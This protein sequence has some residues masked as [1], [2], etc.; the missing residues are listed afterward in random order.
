MYALAGPTLV[1]DGMDPAALVSRAAVRHRRGRHRPRQFIQPRH[2]GG[3]RQRPPARYVAAPV[4]AAHRA[5]LCRRYGRA[6]PPVWLALLTV[7]TAGGAAIFLSPA[8]LFAF[9]VGSATLPSGDPGDAAVFEPAAVVQAAHWLATVQGADDIV[10]SLPLTGNELAADIPG[11]V[12]VGHGMATF[13]FSVK[14]RAAEMFYQ[15]TG[16]RRDRA[17][18][19]SSNHIRYVF[20]G[21][22]ERRLVGQDPFAGLRLSVVY[23]TPAV[24]V[25]Q[26][27]A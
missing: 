27:G 1:S 18:F 19:L 3:R 21:P 7:A 10:L 26:V 2:P 8:I 14:K 22:E 17:A 16:D 24:T 23:Q 13:D 6:R 15:A 11:R 4:L 20:Y 12:Y 25:F 9:V 5:R